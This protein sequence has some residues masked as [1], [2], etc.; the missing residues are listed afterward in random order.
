MKSTP[1]KLEAL[2]LP[3]AERLLKKHN[4]RVPKVAQELGVTPQAFNRW[5]RINNCRRVVTLECER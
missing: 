5:L 2:T 4:Y 3:Q 1:N